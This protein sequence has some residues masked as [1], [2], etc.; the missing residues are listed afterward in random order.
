MMNAIANTRRLIRRLA[1]P[2]GLLLLTVLFVSGT[3]H[4]ADGARHACAVCTVGDSPAVAANLTAPAHAPG[5]PPQA[6]HAAPRYTPRTTRLEI[7]R[8]RAPPLA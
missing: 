8:G 5:S 6:I 2:L 4:H 1:P 7:S 3:H